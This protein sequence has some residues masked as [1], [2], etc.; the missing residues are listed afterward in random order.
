VEGL[1][2]AAIT[3]YIVGLIGYLAK[4]AKELGWP[5]SFEVT[6]ALAIPLVALAVWWSLRKLHRKIGTHRS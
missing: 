4:G 5:L 1:S 2:V 3:Y 6:T